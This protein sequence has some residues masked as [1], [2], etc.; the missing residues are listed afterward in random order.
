[1]CPVAWQT[2]SWSRAV[3]LT[4][5]CC[6]LAGTIFLHAVPAAAALKQ[7]IFIETLDAGF[8]PLIKE[9]A[10]ERLE[11]APALTARR[12]LGARAEARRPEGAARLTETVLFQQGPIDRHARL[13]AFG[14][15]DRYQQDFPRGVSGDIDSLDAALFGDGVGDDS[16]FFISG[17]A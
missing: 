15:G 2:R 8:P 17:T 6:S 5:V 3:A 12:E 1:M 14:D 11:I 10:L 16:A 4:I 13:G 7:V 9:D